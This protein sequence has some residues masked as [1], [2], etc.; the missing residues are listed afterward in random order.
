MWHDIQKHS[1]VI[2]LR[3]NATMKISAYIYFF[4]SLAIIICISI[5]GDSNKYQLGN[6]FSFSSL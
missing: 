3:K 4:F 2:C 5:A 6:S 1:R